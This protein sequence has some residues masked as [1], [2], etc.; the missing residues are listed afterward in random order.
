[1]RIL[2]TGGAGFIGSFLAER[3]VSEGHTVVVLDD[4]ST[5]SL[6]NLASI[7]AHEMFAFRQGSVLDPDTV[8]DLVSDADCVFHLA[9]AVGVRLI[10]EQPS[11]GLLTNIIGTE[12]VLHACLEDNTRVFIASTSEVYGKSTTFPQ[13]ESDDLVIGATDNLR[14]SYACAKMCDE[15]LAL[16]Y[17]RE[18]DLQATILRFFNTTGPRQTSRYGMVIPSF[19]DA[20]L[21][22]R[23]L[24]VHGTGEQ[25]RCFC[26][27]ADVVEALVRLLNRPESAGRVYNIGTDQEV[28]IRELALK[29]IEATGSRSSLDFVPYKDVYGPGF[30]DMQR[31][32]PDLTRI[33][34][35]TGFRP[36]LP[37][38]KIIQ[39]IVADRSSAP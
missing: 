5:G 6:S 2:I 9:A 16:S 13:H 17:V 25:S 20:A 38:E 35:T 8:S 33:E 23:P 12:R 1:M 29:V 26:H 22:G 37:L 15:F 19:V 34:E 31:R 14:W 27:V 36:R 11:A 32:K 18:R 21:E 7:S 3:L 30:E 10:M 4:L 28:T 39:D 24:T